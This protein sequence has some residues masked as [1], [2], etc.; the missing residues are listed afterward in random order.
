MAWYPAW[1]TE[2]ADLYFSGSVCLFVLH[3]NV[4]D[5]IGCPDG[6][7][8]V[9]CSLTEFLT[10]QVFGKWDV[11][12]S[13]DLSRGIRPQ[14]GEDADRLRS[15]VPPP[16]RVAVGPDST[17]EHVRAVT[18]VLAGRLRFLTFRVLWTPKEIASWEERT[19]A[20]QRHLLAD[21]HYKP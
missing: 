11:V 15:M 17:A 12:L 13:H 7:K 5:L 21:P 3:G 18:D 20:H 9:Y 2:L 10:K 1:A 14:A 8:D 16:R 4:H 6:G 19:A